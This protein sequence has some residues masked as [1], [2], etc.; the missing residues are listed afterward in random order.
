[1]VTTSSQDSSSKFSQMGLAV[2]PRSD[3]PPFKTW[4]APGETGSRQVAVRLLRAQCAGLPKAVLRQQ[5]PLHRALSCPAHGPWRGLPADLRTLEACLAAGAR[6]PTCLGKPCVGS[7]SPSAGPSDVG[8]QALRGALL[9]A[10][11]SG[12]VG[13]AGASRVRCAVSIRASN[14]VVRRRD[15]MRREGAHVFTIGPV[16]GKEL[17]MPARIGQLTPVPWCSVSW[18][19][20]Q[21]VRRRRNRRPSPR[22]NLNDRALALRGRCAPGH[23][24]LHSLRGRQRPAKTAVRETAVG[25]PGHR[26][27]RVP[28]RGSSAP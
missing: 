4:H 25:Q 20:K 17:R 21:R 15:Q 27:V 10:A 14:H 8:N 24:G 9:G 19:V 28:R 5:G 18:I 6:T 23:R 3:I 13:R 12:H 22:T 11:C 26:S 7:W 16:P 1:M 2:D